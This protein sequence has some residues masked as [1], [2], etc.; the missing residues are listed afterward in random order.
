MQKGTGLP[1]REQNETTMQEQP[2]LDRDEIVRLFRVLA[3]DLKSP[4]FSIDG[5]SELL[6]ADYSDS[7]DEEGRDFLQRIRNGVDQLKQTLDGFSRT[8]KLLSREDLVEEVD[9][10]ELIE[11]AR[12]KLTYQAE[13]KGVRL[14]LG[15]NFPVVRGDREK[16]RELFLAILSNAIRFSDKREGGSTVEVTHS[17]IDGRAEVRVRDEGTGIAPAF[18]EQIFDAGLRLDKRGPGSG[19][20]LYLARQV[21]RGHGG[22]IAVESAE[23]EGSTFVVRLPA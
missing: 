10:G 21:A 14:E 18:H 5:F 7:L 2:L 11:E 20:G 8:V 4:I 16:L 23:G 19:C 13:E 9:L 6:L 12:L 3:H 22:D 17:V 1:F 15:E